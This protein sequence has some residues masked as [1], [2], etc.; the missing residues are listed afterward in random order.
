MGRYY[1]KETEIRISFEKFITR[2]Y[3]SYFLD[4]F[5]S[6]APLAG[7]Y[8]DQIVKAM[9]VGFQAGHSHATKSATE[10]EVSE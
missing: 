5:R 6:P 1:M 2:N 9:W 4:K 10:C 8:C 3:P 7:V